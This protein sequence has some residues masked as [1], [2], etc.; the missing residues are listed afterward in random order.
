MGPRAQ[1]CG[2]PPPAGTGTPTAPAQ[3]YGTPTVQP[4]TE[5]EPA[6]VTVTLQAADPDA[7]TAALHTLRCHPGIALQPEPRRVSS[8]PRRAHGSRRRR[9]RSPT[10]RVSREHTVGNRGAASAIGTQGCDGSAEDHRP[11]MATAHAAAAVSI[12]SAVRSR[13]A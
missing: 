7:L 1:V 9:G 2:T 6:T 4:S 10:V 5:Q 12:C 13:P 8:A 3:I 11:A